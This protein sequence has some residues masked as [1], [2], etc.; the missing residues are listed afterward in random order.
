MKKLLFFFLFISNTVFGD[1]IN[2][3][4][5][6][7]KQLIEKGIPVVDV[8]TEEEW[9]KTGIIK[10]SFLVSMINKKGRY[11]FQDW[12]Q[13]FSKI[14]LKN[15]SVILMCAVGGRSYY[16]AKTMNGKEKN[17]KIYNV[18][19]GILNWIINHNPIVNYD[20]N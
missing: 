8:R 15:N 6:E 16:L 2:I 20:Q 7:L 3:D 11:S 12:S 14:K 1:V 10:N 17:I 13:R 5:K 18:Q 4:N 9:K 19:K